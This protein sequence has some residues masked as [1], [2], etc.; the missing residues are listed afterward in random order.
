MSRG[1]PDTQ[2]VIYLDE[3]KPILD[4]LGVLMNLRYAIDQASI[5]AI[6]DVQGKFLYVNDMFCEISKYSEE[7]LIGQDHRILNSR[8]HPK[9]FFQEMWHHIGKGEV[10][11]G[12][13]RNRA[14]DGTFYWVNCTIIPILDSRG[15]PY[16]FI[17][18]RNNI[19]DKK[20]LEEKLRLREE[21]LYHLINHDILTEIPNRSFLVDA[22]HKELSKANR[23]QSQLGVLFIDL[24]NFN[25]INDTSGHE[26]GDLILIEVAQ[27]I[28][29]SIRSGDI[30]SRFGGDEFTVLLMNN[31]SE[32]T[33]ATVAKRIVKN[34]NAP[35][36]LGEQTFQVSSRIGI[37]RFPS[38]G[39]DANTLLK[40]ADIALNESK[41]KGRN[42]YTFFRSEMERKYLEMAFLEKEMKIAIA[43]NQFYLEYQP[44][45]E[46]ET[47]RVTGVEALVRWKHPNNGVIPPN[48]FISIAEET[49]MIVP[50]GEWIL[51]HACNQVK[52]FQRMDFPVFRMAI[53]ISVK[54]FLQGDFVRTV[55]EIIEE[56]G[57][58]PNWLEFEITESIFADIER[59]VPILKEIKSLG[60]HLA[61]DDFGKGYSSLGYLKDFPVDVIK[62]DTSF[63]RDLLSNKNS[64]A[65]VRGIL[66]F[67]KPLGLDVVAEGIETKNQLNILLEAGCVRGQGYLFSKP[68]S[69]ESFDK[70]LQQ[71][72]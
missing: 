60:I 9:E 42:T 14:K 52:K 56:T 15:K 32:D 61:I 29:R 71:N 7:E 16:Q 30:L 22:L 5:V 23:L 26:V 55:K 63:V 46:L 47:G 53:N 13:I 68:L 4:F 48:Q 49:G 40:R 57:I 62:I 72:I 64:R 24:Y 59:I 39:E 2:K 45:V 31:P 33:M 17:S 70:Y 10:W 19:T 8:Y 25:V 43:Q 41:E 34:I 1:E 67:S 36:A 21:L 20:E 28:Q 66:S 58:N 69:I 11:R 44:K 54:Q 27:R 35:L 12:D 50:L 3:K 6:T 38:D 51:R 18:I 37:A 65:I